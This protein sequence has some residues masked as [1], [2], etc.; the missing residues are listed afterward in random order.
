M[1]PTSTT[2]PPTSI[3]V[4]FEVWPDA[5]RPSVYFDLAAALRPELDTIDGFISI[6]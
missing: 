2:G 3:A 5:A 1:Q 4:V 6:E